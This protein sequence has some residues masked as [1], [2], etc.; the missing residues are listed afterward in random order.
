MKQ[1]RWGESEKRKKKEDLRR[2]RA[3]RKKMQVREKVEKSLNTVFF[4]CFV[5]QVGRKVGSL[6]RPAR[7]HLWR[8]DMKNCTL[9]WREAG[10]FV[11]QN[12]ENTSV[13]ER[14]WKFRCWKSARGCGAKHISNSKCAKHPRKL[15]RWK[16]A[17]CCGAKPFRCQN[18]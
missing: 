4:P 5:A 15:R 9:L 10:W 16:S 13:L 14:F 11:S 18:A 3:R 2:G 1:Q 17:R 8:W 7:C 6:K 12:V